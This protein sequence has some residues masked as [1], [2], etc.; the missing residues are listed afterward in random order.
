[1]SRALP[2]AAVVVAL[3]GCAPHVRFEDRQILWAW[4]DDRPVPMPNKRVICLAWE[5]ARDGLFAPAERVLSLDYLHEARNVNALDELP[6]SSWF[7]D[8]RRVPG[9]ARP[10]A[11]PAEELTWG[12]LERDDV[13]VLP[14]VVIRGKDLGATPGFVVLDARGRKYMVKLDP[15]GHVGI[16][17]STE[18]V[19][20][21]LGWAAGWRV[22]AETL[23]DVW[24]DQIR[25]DPSA[26]ANDFYDQPMPFTARM[27]DAILGRASR[28]ANGSLRF[29][30]SRWLPGVPLGGF[31][32]AGRVKDDPNDL[33]DHEDRRDLRAFGVFAAWV[34]DIDTFDNNTLDMYEGEPGRGH[35]V[36][37]QQDVG[38]SF[39]NWTGV[40]APYWTGSETFLE[41]H[42]IVRSLLTLGF[43]PRPF[44]DWRYRA[45]KEGLAK[46]WPEL[47][48]FEAA[49]FD[50]RAWRPMLENAAFARQTA[51]DRYWGAKR[52]AAFSDDELRAA[53]VAGRYRP[54]AAERLF[55]LLAQRRDKIA[56]AYFADVTP[57]DHFRLDGERLCFDDLW[58][59]ARLGGAAEYRASVPASLPVDGGRCV[60]LPGGRGYRIVALAVRRAGE[61]RFGKPVRVHIINDERPRI[62]GVER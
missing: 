35:V 27:L 57:L 20:T 44:D 58:V 24:P 23:V 51:R 50:P 14:L 11:I 47:G 22:P 53:I 30:A 29:V 17:S 39:G 37:Y 32:Y 49:K 33:I 54:G 45:W 10:R 38:G 15:P 19:V 18:V 5:D 61:R 59:E 34:N 12:A 55:Q 21:R 42:L 9:Q 36:H 26:T 6:D 56:R 43:W 60:T 3:A 13:P 4:P 16:T 7:V 52:V 40:P 25:L 41:A 28:N 2:I 1:M 46:Q 62:I 31:A 48:V 8:P